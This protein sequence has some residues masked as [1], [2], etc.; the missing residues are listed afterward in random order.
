MEGHVSAIK[1]IN[2]CKNS[3]KNKNVYK[4]RLLSKTSGGDTLAY[5]IWGDQVRVQSETT[6]YAKVR[7]RGQT[8]YI[9]KDHY[10]DKPL[11]EVYVID[12]GQGDGVL[13]RTPD[14]KWHMMDAGVLNSVQ[15]TKKGAPNFVRWKFFNDLGLRKI[16]IENMILSHPD[17]DHYGG[18]INI[19]E[20]NLEDDRTFAIEVENFYHSGMARFASNPELGKSKEVTV[21]KFPLP[22]HGCKRKTNLIHELL[23]DKLSFSNPR[24]KLKRGR[25]GKLWGSFAHL[26]QL[27]GSIPKNVARI[28]SDTNY[29]PG[30]GP[31]Q[32]KVKMKVLGPIVEKSGAIEGLRKFSNKSKIRNGHSVILR[33]DYGK[34]KLLLT[35]DTN[36]ESQKLTLSYIPGNEF[37]SDVAKGCHHGSEDIYLRFIKEM[38]ARATVISSGDNEDYAHPRPVVMGASA[39]YGREIKD[40]IY[41]TTKPPLIYSTELAR[42]V[43]LAYPTRVQVEESDQ[44]GGVKKT[45]IAANQTNIKTKYTSYQKT[46]RSPVSTDLIYGLVNIRTDG[47]EI[48]CAT[49]EEKGSDFDLKVFKAG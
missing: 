22:N 35:G 40:Q 7:A 48:M 8:G 14:L 1:Y 10:S 11:L 38:A 4:T 2:K 33:L 39:F 36:E 21:P 17:F 5:L 30:Y 16:S 12:V 44:A 25:E 45:S 15:M 13:F 37:K 42:S 46:E 24:R 9:L 18:F 28:S 19:L 32:N 6:K 3:N 49:M 29:L 26:G 43:K 23:D 41:K 31:N 27:V 47:N 34:A 20:G